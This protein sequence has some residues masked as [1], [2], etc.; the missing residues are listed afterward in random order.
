MTDPKRLTNWEL[1]QLRF[2]AEQRE[3][4]DVAGKDLLAL[5]NEVA[6]IRRKASHPLAPAAHRG[7]GY[8]RSDRRQARYTMSDD[9]PPGVSSE[10][11]AAIRR[12]NRSAILADVLNERVLEWLRKHH[13]GASFEVT[14][15]D[16]IRP[17]G[18]HPDHFRVE[19]HYRTSDGYVR[20]LHVEGMNLE[21]LWRHV[22]GGE[23]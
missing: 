19:L 8:R 10:E 11:A 4:V 15:V 20:G 18:G 17:V 9:L 22:V 14:E 13:E 3:I 16:E 12:A 21:S 5:R 23:E 6:A 2:A 7:S 1:D